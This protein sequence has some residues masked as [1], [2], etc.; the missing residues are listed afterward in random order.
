PAPGDSFRAQR[1]R[2]A[3]VNGAP[4]RVSTVDRLPAAT[5]V[6]SSLN[7]LRTIEGWRY[8]DGFV[9]LVDRTDRQR[10]WGDYLAYTFVL[11]GQAEAVV[12]T[13]LTP[14]GLAPFSVLFLES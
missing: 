8:W 1:G 6:H 9:R 13:D 10:G 2:G 3:F 12:E 4:L 7:L 11:R 14:C 5:L